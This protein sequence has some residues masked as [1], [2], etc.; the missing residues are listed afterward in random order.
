MTYWPLSSECESV[1]TLQCCYVMLVSSFLPVFQDNLSV[2]SSKAYQS[3]KS[4]SVV[5]DVTAVTICT[6]T[7]VI[8]PI[9]REAVV[10][11]NRNYLGLVTIGMWPF[12]PYHTDKW[13]TCCN[14]KS[15]WSYY[16]VLCAILCDSWTEGYV[17]TVHAWPWTWC[18]GNIFPFLNLRV[19]SFRCRPFNWFINWNWLKKIGIAM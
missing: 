11:P 17:V 4:M 2:S 16:F 7:V 6:L 12:T 1:I 18:L 14:Y 3:H 8:S 15:T 5:A 19:I 9:L 13:K 10:L